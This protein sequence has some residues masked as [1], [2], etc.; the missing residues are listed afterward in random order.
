VNRQQ[1]VAAG[2]AAICLGSWLLYEAYEGS[3]HKRPFWARF[4]PGA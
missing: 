3:G 2:V 4:L 1:T